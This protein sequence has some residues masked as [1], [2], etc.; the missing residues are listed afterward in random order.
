M[1]TALYR[2]FYKR[3]ARDDFFQ[4]GYPPIRNLTEEEIHQ[5]KMADGYRLDILVQLH[6][7]DMAHQWYAPRVPA[8]WM[9]LQIALECDESELIARFTESDEFE[10]RIDDDADGRALSA[11]LDNFSKG[12]NLGARWLCDLLR[13]E[14]L[15]GARWR[16]EHN[17]RV[18]E[19]A[20]DVAGV[21]ESLLEDNLFP[22]D[23]RPRTN[24]ALFHRG[25]SGITEAPLNREQAR[26][27]RKL[28]T[29]QDVSGDK[30]ATVKKCRAILR[31]IGHHA[32]GKAASRKGAR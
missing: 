27:M 5:L 14:L 17:P 4:P 23:E 7:R 19:F 26:V 10:L 22:T 30:P 13:Y 28:L 8:S 25:E 24:A 12:R 20:W 16:D 1:Y 9:A 21:R 29:G 31:K 6:Q 32:D 18:E 11:W 2:L 15:L 3:G